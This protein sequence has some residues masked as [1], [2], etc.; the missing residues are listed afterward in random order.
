MGKR[1]GQSWKTDRLRLQ[2]VKVFGEKGVN[3]LVTK[4]QEYSVGSKKANA[5]LNIWA[6]IGGS[7]NPIAQVESSV[8]TG[9][10][11]ADPDGDLGLCPPAHQRPSICQSLQ[12]VLIPDSVKTGAISRLQATS[13]GY[14]GFRP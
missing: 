6:F 13:S 3:P 2:V 14:K 12:G 5:V 11:N 9:T 1:T 10:F 7:G 8:G 4:R